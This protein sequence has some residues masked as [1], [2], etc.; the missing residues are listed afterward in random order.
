M[1]EMVD[2]SINRD[3]TSLDQVKPKQGVYGNE[4]DENGVL[5]AEGKYGILPVPK[6]QDP[7]DPKIPPAP[8]K[9]AHVSQASYQPQKSLMGS[10]L[11]GFA[12]SQAVSQIAKKLG[13]TKFAGNIGGFWGTAIFTIADL[14]F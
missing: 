11:T 4:Y 14:L 9:G 3:M 7:Q 12:A 13:H 8:I 5:I 1:S 6:Y 2:P 10:A